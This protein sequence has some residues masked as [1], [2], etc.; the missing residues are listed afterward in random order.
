[1]L[2]IV[3]MAFVVAVAAAAKVKDSRD[4]LLR[5]DATIAG[6]QLRSGVYNVQYQTHSPEATV[7]FPQGNKVVATAEGKV[8]DRGSKYS[9]NE[10]VYAGAAE[11]PVRSRKS[12]SGD[13]AKSSSSTS[14]FGVRGTGMG[15]WDWGA[16]GARRRCL[17][18][19]MPW[20][21]G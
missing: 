17:P 18:G 13:R 5:F 4:V 20:R 7:S 16:C 9:S 3:A 15:F 14:S 12:A 6:S 2:T 10:V 8:V 19:S 21:Y 11:A 1:M